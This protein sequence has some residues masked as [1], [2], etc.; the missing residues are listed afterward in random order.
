ML[1]LT[2]NSP[3]HSVYDV[4]AIFNYESNF[5]NKIKLAEGMAGYEK[6]EK[7]AQDCIIAHTGF[8]YQA[9]VATDFM[10]KVIAMEDEA[11]IK[12]AESIAK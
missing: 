3:H 10:D 1:K 8:G 9:I 2:Y 4:R 7:Y 5:A 6:I 11:F 12:W